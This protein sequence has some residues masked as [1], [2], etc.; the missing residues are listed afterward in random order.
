MMLPGAEIVFGED[1]GETRRMKLSKTVSAYLDG[2]YEALVPLE[3]VKD[4]PQPGLSV[5]LGVAIGLE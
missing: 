4:S 1:D 2:A 5:S 3:R